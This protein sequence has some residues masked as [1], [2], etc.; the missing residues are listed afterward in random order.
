MDLEGSIRN[1]GQPGHAA[2][3]NG[4]M[5]SIQLFLLSSPIVHYYSINLLTSAN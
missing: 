5:G 1:S 2:T 3:G 4:R